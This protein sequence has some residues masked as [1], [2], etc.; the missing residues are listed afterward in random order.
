MQV[1]GHA[2][3]GLGCNGLMLKPD[4]GVNAV[5]LTEAGSALR[6]LLDCTGGVVTGRCRD[7]GQCQFR[8]SEVLKFEL[9]QFARKAA[10]ADF[11]ATANCK[12]SMTE[13]S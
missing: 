6:R 12:R 7:H 8:L 1:T 3:A 10:R 11:M 13:D 2:Q 4:Q 5:D 9:C